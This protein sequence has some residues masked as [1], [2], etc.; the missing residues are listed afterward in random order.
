MTSTGALPQGDLL[1]TPSEVERLPQYQDLWF[2]DGS[3]VIAAQ[4]TSY[5]LHRGVLA[6]HCGVFRDMFSV[7][8]G[9]QS[10]I[11]HGCPVVQ[12]HDRSEHLTKFFTLIYD[13]AKE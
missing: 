6:R 8:Q 10:L 12:L 4:A 5:R 2:E 7:P 1:M 11:A 9:G 13:G 3:I